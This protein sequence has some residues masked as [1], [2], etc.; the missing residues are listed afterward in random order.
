MTTFRTLLS[1]FFAGAMVGQLGG[2]L[3]GRAILPWWNTPGHGQALCNCP[4]LV[5][6][7]VGALIRYQLIGAIAGAVVAV[8]LGIWVLRWRARPARA[9][10]G[11]SGA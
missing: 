3:L 11:G 6:E 9:S 10:A 1:F 7:T 5:H 4:E 8:A 2:T